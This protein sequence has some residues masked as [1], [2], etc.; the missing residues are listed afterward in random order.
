MTLPE[1][2]VVTEA[3]TLRGA[4]EAA[5]QALGV[6]ASLVEHRID[7][8]HF[9]SSTGQGVGMDTV[10]IFAWARD[11]STMAPVLAA[12][13][14]MKTTLEAMG[15][16]GSVR[17]DR[18]GDAVVIFVDVGEEGRHLV[19][20]GGSALRA[21]QHLLEGA[22]A[23]E[24]P[25]QV[26]RIDVARAEG[27]GER[28]EERGEHGDREERRGDRGDRGDRGERSRDR[29]DRGD[30]SRDRGDRGGDRGG[31]G[32]R[33]QDEGELKKLARKLALK[34]AETGNPE[35]IR[36]ELNGFERRIVHVEVQEIAGVKTR[37]I[38]EGSLKKV[39]IYRED[40]GTEE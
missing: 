10:K 39:E 8:A 36:R 15:R 25:G 31:R 30:R 13:T 9:R 26:F 23:G 27:E 29:G 34:V 22:L 6:P 11:A 3:R 16:S 17:A 35:V 37:S 32:E 4:I 38:G 14:W 18:R 5:A 19:G 33:R 21:L 1:N 24:F 28:R 7:T 40:S 20:R 2:H 12:E